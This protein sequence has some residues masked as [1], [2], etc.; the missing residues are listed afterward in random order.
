MNGFGKQVMS[1]L[2][3]D[4]SESSIIDIVT[5]RWYGDEK[6]LDHEMW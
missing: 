2:M 4:I 5:A 3:K 1:S 6:E